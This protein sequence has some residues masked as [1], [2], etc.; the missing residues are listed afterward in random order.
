MFKISNS[1]TLL[2]FFIL[3]SCDQKISENDLN[4]YK[5]IMDIRLGHLGNAIIIKGRLLTP[6]I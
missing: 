3:I 6:S 2:I 4:E 1:I 5:S